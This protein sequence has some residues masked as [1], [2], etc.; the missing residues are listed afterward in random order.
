L[1]NV[2]F[3]LVNVIWT[4]KAEG[5]CCSLFFKDF[6]SVCAFIQDVAI[7]A[8]A[9]DHHPDWRNVHCRMDIC[10]STHDEGNAVTKKDLLL[11]EEINRILLSYEWKNC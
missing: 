11:S 9:M 6:L 10:L 5:L 1:E 7:V 4:Q 2:I 8:E 3:A